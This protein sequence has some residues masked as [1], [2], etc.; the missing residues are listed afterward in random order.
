MGVLPTPVS[1]GLEAAAMGLRAI[2]GLATIAQVSADLAYGNKELAFKD[3]AAYFGTN[4][5]LGKA[6]TAI[7]RYR[8]AGPSMSPEHAQAFEKVVDNATNIATGATY[9]KPCK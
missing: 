8:P 2:S 7:N 6:G 4:I 9:P 5:P 1:P 3:A